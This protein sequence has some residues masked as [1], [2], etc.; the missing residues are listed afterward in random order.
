MI[1]AIGR[2]PGKNRAM[3]RLEINSADR[4]RSEP[5]SNLA[6]EAGTV[7]APVLHAMPVLSAWMGEAD[8]ATCRADQTGFAEVSNP[9]RDC[10]RLTTNSTRLCVK[11]RTCVYT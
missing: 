2:K 7:G 1:T 3:C 11:L 9:C 10:A 4:M 5:G 6:L 8:K